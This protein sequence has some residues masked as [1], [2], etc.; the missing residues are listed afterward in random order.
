M[1]ANGHI[2]PA[3]LSAVRLHVMIMA[4]IGDILEHLIILIAVFSQQIQEWNAA[5]SKTSKKI[6]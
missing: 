6:K 5:E 3:L 2:V 4:R 1:N